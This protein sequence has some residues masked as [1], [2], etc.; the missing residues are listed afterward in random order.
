MNLFVFNPCPKTSALWLD[1][2]RKNKIILECAQMLSTAIHQLVPNHS[3]DIYKQS[4]VNHPCSIWVR[5]S[6]ANFVWTIRYMESLYLQRQRPHKSANLLCLFKNF[7]RA[8]VFPSSGL[9]PFANC[10][11]RADQGID[12]T[13]V[14]D[15]H[16]AY[17][18]Y[19]VERWSNDRSPPT[20]SHGNQPD[21][22][23]ND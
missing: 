11:R 14:A 1:D 2:I 16:E 10:A 12:Y 7:S 21:W 19:I 9:T 3:L 4:Y 23:D 6:Q 13:G 15:T 5:A 22:R 8:N 17:R 20:W 18:Q